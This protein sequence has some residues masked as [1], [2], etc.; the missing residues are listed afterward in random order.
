MLSLTKLAEDILAN[1]KRLD[2]Y[3]SSQSLPPTSF[4]NDTLKDLPLD[5]EAARNSLIDSTQLL[6][7][8]A[9]GPVGHLIEISFGVSILITFALEAHVN[10][11]L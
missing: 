7:R 3:T 2:E 9:L 5:L 6:K 10:R 4:D 8:L 1:A 11:R